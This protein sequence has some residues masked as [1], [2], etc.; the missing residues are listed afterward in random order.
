LSIIEKALKRYRSISYS[1]RYGG[2]VEDYKLA[3]QVDQTASTFAR[4]TIASGST[5][6]PTASKQPV[7]SACKQSI[8]LGI[9][10]RSRAKPARCGTALLL[11]GIMKR[12][13]HD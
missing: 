2:R 12:R 13:N 9:P 8:L 11:I 7:V 5:G 4:Y 3:Q 1:N 6:Y 10:P